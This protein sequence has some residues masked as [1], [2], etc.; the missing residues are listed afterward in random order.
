MLGSSK[1]YALS[2]T[3]RFGHTSAQPSSAETTFSHMISIP[4][5]SMEGVGASSSCSMLCTC[6]RASD[7]SSYHIGYMN[8]KPVSHIHNNL[9]LARSRH[10]MKKQKEIQVGASHQWC[11]VEA[12][13]VDVGKEMDLHH[14]KAKWEQWGGIVERGQPNSLVLFRLPPKTAAVR[15]PGPGPITKRDW[16]PVAQTLRVGM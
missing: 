12:D 6:G 10:V 7:F 15:S 1:V 9:E 13:E 4:F 16:K 8:H 3:G 5:S 14:K 2:K 11:D